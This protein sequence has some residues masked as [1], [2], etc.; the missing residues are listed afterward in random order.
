MKKIETLPACFAFFWKQNSFFFSTIK[1]SYHHLLA[2]LNLF[3]FIS[4]F[5]PPKMLCASQSPSALHFD[6]SN[7]DEASKQRQDLIPED[8]EEQRISKKQHFHL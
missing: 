4:L 8:F 2:F 7:Q 3:I 1:L 6:A 5:H